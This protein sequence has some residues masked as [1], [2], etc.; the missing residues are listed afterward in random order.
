MA[1]FF[2]TTVVQVMH[3]Q[4]VI[5][6]LEW[7]HSAQA[8]AICELCVWKS[9]PTV[10]LDHSG[11]G[12]RETGQVPSLWCISTAKPYF[13]TLSPSPEGCCREA[14]ALYGGA[15][16]GFATPETLASSGIKCAIPALVAE[17]SKV[18]ASHSLCCSS[19]G[20]ASMW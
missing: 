20:R 11:G 7:A 1:P 14:H 18:L 13:I 8:L 17:Q 12:E 16:P 3:L 5:S 10:H 19:K 9:S 15:R 4:R 6:S 2:P